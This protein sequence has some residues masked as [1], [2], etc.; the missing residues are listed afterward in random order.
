M[1]A[2]VLTVLLA[3]ST[4]AWAQVE[5]TEVP[6]PGTEAPAATPS[7]ESM[8][9]APRPWQPGLAWLIGWNMSLGTFDTFTFASNYSFR[10]VSLEARYELKPNLALGVSGAWHVLEER[11]EDVTATQ[12]PRTVTGTQIRTLNFVPILAR[13][14]YTLPDF[15]GDGTELWGA[16]GLGTYYIEKQ[17]E[18]GLFGNRD[19]SWHFGIAPEIGAAAEIGVDYS[20][21]VSTA[22][23]FAFESGPTSTQSYVNFNIGFKHR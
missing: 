9:S 20:I 8:K 16:L 10:G 4:P 19:T 1:R 5:M 21:F 2:L 17:L 12:G 6:A 11:E 3:A 23:N 22:W 18:V 13:A 15:L 14:T 7:P